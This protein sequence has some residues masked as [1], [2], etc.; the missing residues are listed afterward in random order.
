M[1]IPDS[2]SGRWLK[3]VALEGFGLV[4]GAKCGFMQVKTD[5]FVEEL[6]A[7]WDD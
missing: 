4:E 7:K 6:K 2:K 1:A 3:P 5:D